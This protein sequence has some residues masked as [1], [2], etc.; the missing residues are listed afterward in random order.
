MEALE[1]DIKKR[2]MEEND[3]YIIQQKK[4]ITK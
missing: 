3:K 2:I 4:E 1:E